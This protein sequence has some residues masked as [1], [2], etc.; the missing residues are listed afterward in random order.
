[1]LEYHLEILCPQLVCGRRKEEKGYIFGCRGY[2]G[3]LPVKNDTLKRI[4]VIPEEDILLPELAVDD[5]VEGG[6]DLSPHAAK[7]LRHARF[8]LNEILNE[9]P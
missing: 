9:L 7:H 2:F 5:S 3:V 4:L 8:S 1:M 6:G